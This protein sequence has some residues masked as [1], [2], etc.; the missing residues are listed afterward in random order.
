MEEIFYYKDG[1]DKDCNVTHICT[2]GNKYTVCMKVDIL[3]KI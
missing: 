1:N 3:K 2:I